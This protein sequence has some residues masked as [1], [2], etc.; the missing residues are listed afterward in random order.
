[1]GYIAPELDNTA[2]EKQLPG[3]SGPRTE[4]VNIW[5]IGQTIRLMMRHA[6]K[7]TPKDFID[8]GS[9]QPDRWLLPM[10]VANDRY[11]EELVAIVRDCVVAAPDERATPD[12]IVEACDAYEERVKASPES[13]ESAEKASEAIERLCFQV[14]RDAYKHGM[15][16]S[17]LPSGRHSTE[18]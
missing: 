4:A 14:R 13:A 2:R 10:G 3:A 16:L 5:Q 1:M 11:S 15:V 18:G 6:A 12:R 17:R 7:A 8:Y 9:T